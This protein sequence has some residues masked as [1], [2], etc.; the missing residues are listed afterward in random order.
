MSMPAKKTPNPDL[1]GREPLTAD[2]NCF[3]R[4]SVAEIAD[5]IK[6]RLEADSRPR[7]MRIFGPGIG[8]VTLRVSNGRVFVDPD[9]F[10]ALNAPLDNLLLGLKLLLGYTITVG[11]PTEVDNG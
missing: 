8:P 6:Q 2:N 10:L 1:S 7:T 5:L 4:E 3:V 9:I 11:R